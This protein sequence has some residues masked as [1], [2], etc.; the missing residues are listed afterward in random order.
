MLFGAQSAPRETLFYPGFAADVDGLQVQ[1]F[2]QDQK[3]RSFA[4][5]DGADLVVDA[6]GTGRDGA[7]SIDRVGQVADAPGHQVLD[8]LQQAGG[9][10]G[11]EWPLRSAHRHRPENWPQNQHTGSHPFL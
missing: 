11:P 4:R 6:G 7:G 8:L 10:A 5:F 9:G 3:I 2:G 1:V